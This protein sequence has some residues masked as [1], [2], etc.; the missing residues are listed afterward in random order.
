MSDTH[1][2][3]RFA[4]LN[5]R[6]V[7]R[8]SQLKNVT[9]A[10]EQITEEFGTEMLYSRLLNLGRIPNNY[11]DYRVSGASEIFVEDWEEYLS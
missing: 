9:N 11:D 3:V 1:R 7:S 4:N 8:H 2:N 5:A 6:R 10:I